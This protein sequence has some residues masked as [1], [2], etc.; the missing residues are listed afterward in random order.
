MTQQYEPELTQQAFHPLKAAIRIGGAF[1]LIYGSFMLYNRWQS[2]AVAQ[3]P[4]SAPVISRSASNISEL[5]RLN[6][7][8]DG[9]YTDADGDTFACPQAP[10]TD[11]DAQACTFVRSKAGNSVAWQ[12]VTVTGY[13]GLYRI[14][15]TSG[16]KYHC[17]SIP[18]S[19]SGLDACYK[20][21]Q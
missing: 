6:D 8:G 1:V 13:I 20:V 21:A 9:T 2:P 10:A 5:L 19:P 12:P 4:V 15:L 11:A 14:T 17:E 7:N 18:T 16:V 3:T